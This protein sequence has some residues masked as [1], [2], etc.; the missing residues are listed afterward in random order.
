[1]PNF[2]SRLNE[3]CAVSTKVPRFGKG[4]QT[5]IAKELG[6]SQEAVRK[7]FA[8]ETIPRRGIAARLAKLLDVEYSWLVMGAAYGEVDE[9]IKKAKNHDAAVYA[10]V[11]YVIVKNVGVS[12]CGEDHSADMFIIDNGVT[13]YICAKAA[14]ETKSKGVFVVTFRKIQVKESTTVAVFNEISKDSIVTS[15]YLEIPAE[16]WQ[17]K[18]VKT[19]GNEVT[20]TFS[21]KGNSYEAGGVKLSNFL[22]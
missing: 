16:A 19:S 22:G 20:L 4:Q 18:N 1:M 6:C 8:G 10:T 7:W 3:S 9:I 17:G 2:T 5:Y 12:L 11:A 21:R 14:A 13:R 15:T